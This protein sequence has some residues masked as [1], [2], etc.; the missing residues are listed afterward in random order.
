MHHRLGKLA[1]GG[2]DHPAQINI[3]DKIQ[4]LC[5]ITPQ[6]PFYRGKDVMFHIN[7]L[8]DKIQIV[9]INIR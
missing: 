5:F 2:F 6:S 3:V 8:T 1:A 9:L 7:R 4:T